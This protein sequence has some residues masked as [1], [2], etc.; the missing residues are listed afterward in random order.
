MPQGFGLKDGKLHLPKLSPIR[1][2][3]HRP[4]EGIAKHVTIT[5]TPGGEYYASF[6]CEVEIPEPEHKGAIIGIDLGVRDFVVTSEGEHVPAPKHL[7]QAEKR[8]RR[9]Q[10]HLSRCKKG[11]HG[12]EKARLAVAKQHDKVAN[13]RADFLHKLSRRMVDENQVICAESLHVKGMLA[14]HHLAKS[15]SDCG[16]SEY[17]RQLKYKGEWYGCDLL[18][19]ERFFPSS[20]RCHHCG[21]ILDSLPLSVRKWTCPVCGAILDRDENAAINIKAFCTVGTTGTHTPG[22]SPVGDS[23]NPEAPAFRRG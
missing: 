6:C 12:R 7:H 9:L 19:C 13:R 22:E 16:W 20:K 8:L 5:K 17:L 2:V 10:R 11:S 3:L 4:M 18:Q 14:N 21:Y 23:S 1:I 15:I